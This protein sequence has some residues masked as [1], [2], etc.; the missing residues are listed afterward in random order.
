MLLSWDEMAPPLESG[1]LFASAAAAE[2]EAD[3]VDFN[4]SRQGK[5]LDHRNDSAFKCT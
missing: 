5:I 4:K 2:E 3:S 1:C